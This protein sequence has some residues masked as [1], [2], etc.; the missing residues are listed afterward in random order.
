MRELL[1]KTFQIHAGSALHDVL[2]QGGK[3][4]RAGLMPQDDGL[5]QQVLISARYKEGDYERVSACFGRSVVNEGDMH[6]GKPSEMPGFLSAAFHEIVPKS[7]IRPACGAAH[8]AVLDLS[9]YEDAA[10]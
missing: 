3:D 10:P 5:A 7:S 4:V 6:E 2:V 9:D 8:C 1:I